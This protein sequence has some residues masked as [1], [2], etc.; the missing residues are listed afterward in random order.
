MSRMLGSSFSE[1]DWAQVQARVDDGERRRVQRKHDIEHLSLMCR[2][3]L[4]KMNNSTLSR[5]VASKLIHE[6]AFG[7]FPCYG[8]YLNLGRLG[9]A[10][11]PGEGQLHEITNLGRAHAD[12]ITK[13]ECKRLH[14]HVVQDGG[15][16]GNGDCRMLCSCGGWSWTGRAGSYTSRNMSKSFHAHAATAD[17]VD[18]L[19]AGLKSPARAEG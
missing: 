3:A 10:E 16:I 15:L 18:K 13:S 19:A 12:I 4:L 9:L 11:R 17:G 8:D 14:I 1:S 6:E 7:E 2:I 5:G